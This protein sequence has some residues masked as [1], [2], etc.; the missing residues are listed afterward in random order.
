MPASTAFLLYNNVMTVSKKD[1][2]H[3]A[4]LA[5]LGLSESEKELFT[6]QLNSILSHVEII[7]SLDTKNISP[8]A[9]SQLSAV[10]V[11]GTPMREDIVK[12]FKDT[13]KIMATA[14]KVEENMFR[15][16]KIMEEE[17]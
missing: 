8:T 12:Q 4:K 3:V 10:E 17:V 1:T 2:E 11:S 6:A 15:V 9:H 13:D 14:P 5:R 16:P 7:N